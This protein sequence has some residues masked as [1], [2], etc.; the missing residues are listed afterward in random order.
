MRIESDGIVDGKILDKYGKRGSEMRFGMPTFSLPIKI[1]DAPAQ[2]KSFALIMED[3]DAIKV[4]G[5]VWIHWLVANLHDTIIEE[6]S[7]SNFPPYIQGNNSWRDNS[8]GGPTPPD[9]AHTYD[10]TVY[11]LTSDLNLRGGF[12]KN[13]LEQEMQDKVLSTST[14]HGT[15]DA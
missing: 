1:I 9:C 8:Y 3:K 12:D 7:S 4:A 14:I 10:I 5:K 2:A 6:N 15:Y 13:M 11:A